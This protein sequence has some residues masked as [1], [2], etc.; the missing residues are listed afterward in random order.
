MH[1]RLSATA[2]RIW[3]VYILLTIGCGV[4]Y[5]L[6]GMDGFSAVNYAMTTTATGGFSIHNDSIAH[7]HSPT[8]EYIAIVFQF[9]SGINFSMLFMVM[10]KRKLTSWREFKRSEKSKWSEFL[11][12]EETRFYIIAVTACTIVIALI[13]IFSNGLPWKRRS[14]SRSSR[15]CRS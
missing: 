4:C 8:I 6:A 13:L 10:A 1:P 12:N 5:A 14:A 15:W 3:W 2:M 11:G 7:F 9:L